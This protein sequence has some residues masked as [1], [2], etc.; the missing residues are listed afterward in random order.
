MFV[1]LLLHRVHFYCIVCIVI[2]SCALFVSVSADEGLRGRNVLIYSTLC[3][4]RCSTSSLFA[5][6]H[7]AMSLYSIM[8]IVI[9]SCALLLHCVH[10][11]CI[12]CIFIALRAWL[13]HHVHCHCIA[14]MVIAS[15]ALLLRCVHGYCIT[16]IVIA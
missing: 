8:R 3:Y 12:T 6:S 9:A 7:V 5:I 16:C 13:L 14:C 2:A 4:V 1:V 15:R 10:C 11:Y